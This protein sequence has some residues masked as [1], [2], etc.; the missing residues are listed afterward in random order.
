MSR[1]YNY[2][3]RTERLGPTSGL[4][5]R[6][7]LPVRVRFLGSGERPRAT[8]GPSPWWRAGGGRVVK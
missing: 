2:K 7:K 6:D 4:N 3:V 1:E 8:V 5:V